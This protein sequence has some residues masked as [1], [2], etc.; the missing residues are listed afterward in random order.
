MRDSHRELVV[1]PVLPQ[2]SLSTDPINQNGEAQKLNGCV[3]S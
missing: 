1:R 3:T 2:M